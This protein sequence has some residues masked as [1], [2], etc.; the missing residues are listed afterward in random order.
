[1]TNRFEICTEHG[2]IIAM[3]CAKFQTE[4]TIEVDVA[5]ER[6]FARFELNVSFGQISYIAQPPWFESLGNDIYNSVLK[7]SDLIS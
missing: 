1:M 3:P 5:D 6:D 4:W 7:Y 2:T